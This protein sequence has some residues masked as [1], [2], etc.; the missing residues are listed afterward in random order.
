LR[1]FA[2]RVPK[3]LPHLCRWVVC[4]LPGSGLVRAPACSCAKAC[5]GGWVQ[6]PAAARGPAR[7]VAAEK[8]RQTRGCRA[9]AVGHPARIPVAGI[10]AMTVMPRRQGRWAPRAGMRMAVGGGHTGLAP[11]LSWRLMAT[12]VLRPRR[13]PRELRQKPGQRGV[14]ALMACVLGVH[15]VRCLTQVAVAAAQ[16]GSPAALAPRRARV[17]VLCQAAHCGQRRRTGACHPA[18]AAAHPPLALRP[19]RLLRRCGAM[20]VMRRLW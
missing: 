7:T 9:P 18:P 4:R 16:A 1:A 13:L 12:A 2:T 15:T 17:V 20:T 3:L 14:A 6:H 5:C 8:A 11:C 10:P 19:P